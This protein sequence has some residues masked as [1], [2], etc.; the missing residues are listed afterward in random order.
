[1][2]IDY[3]V[4]SESDEHINMLKRVA[5]YFIDSEIAGGRPEGARMRE[6]LLRRFEREAPDVVLPLN[7]TKVRV[8][9]FSFADEM[10]CRILRRILSGDLGEKYIVL[11]SLGDS[12]KENISVALRER[13]LVCVY[14]KPDTGTEILGKI[15]E[16]LKNT[17]FAAVNK[18][19]ITARDI[20]D[21]EGME[22]ISAASNRLSRLKDMGL[23]TKANDEIVTGGGWQYIYEPVK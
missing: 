23:L 19:K 11:E 2:S 12:H 14:I 8:V 6:D 5:P 4:F 20:L 22:N 15:S 10:I 3:T 9:D 13:E 21:L 1:M 16:E 7:F 18:G 17:Y